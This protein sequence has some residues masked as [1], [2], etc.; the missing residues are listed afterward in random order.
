[1]LYLAS[2]KSKVLTWEQLNIRG[3]QGP[4]YCILCKRDE[5]MTQHLFMDCLFT[6]STFD[7]IFEHFGTPYLY[8]ASTR[9][10]L[11]H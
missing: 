6:K 7:A 4:S 10:Y 3:I 2:L 1:M 8:K 9:L 5:E 11:E